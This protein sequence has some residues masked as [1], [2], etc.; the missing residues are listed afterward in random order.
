[1]TG[2]PPIFYFDTNSPYAY[3]AAQRVGKLIPDAVWRPVALPMI[4][5][6]I[7][8]VPWSLSDERDAGVAECERRAAERGLP[9]MRWVDGW[10]AE[11]W[12]FDPIRAAV[13]AEEHGKV[14]PFALECY[15]LMFAEGRSLE[16]IE[17]VRA[18][19]AA[20]GLDPDEVEARIGE[21]AVKERLRAYTDEAVGLGAV[22]VPT[23]AAGGELFWGDDRLEEAAAAASA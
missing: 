19:A 3:L 4:F 17:N 14:V 6:A 22:G 20:V 7:G 12:S 21:D 8:K 23:V 5:R 10:P 15:R 13:V 9:P 18:A 11:S 2:A 16:E 1:M